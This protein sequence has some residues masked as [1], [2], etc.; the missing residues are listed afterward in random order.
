MLL[1]QSN[2]ILKRSDLIKKLEAKRDNN[3]VQSK[4]VQQIETT[5]IPVAAKSTLQTNF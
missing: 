4:L 3:H 2:E 1:E 5:P